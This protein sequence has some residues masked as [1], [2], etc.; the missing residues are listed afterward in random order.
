MDRQKHRWTDR[1]TDKERKVGYKNK[2]DLN[3]ENGPKYED[4]CK[5]EYSHKKSKIVIY[6][7]FIQ[8]FSIFTE[9]IFTFP[10]F[11]I[12]CI[13]CELEFYK[14]DIRLIKLRDLSD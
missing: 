1:Q 6:K 10:N 2:E 11:P 13:Q 9:Q 4:N 8:W 7:V 12:F 14:E 3:I 5:H